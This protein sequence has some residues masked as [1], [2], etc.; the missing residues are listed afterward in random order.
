MTFTIWNDKMWTT[1]IF[2][3]LCF[4]LQNPQD[5]EFA[6]HEWW[7]SLYECSVC[8]WATSFHNL[9]RLPAMWM[10]LIEYASREPNHLISLGLDRP[11]AY[12]LVLL[13]NVFAV[14]YYIFL[15]F[16]LYCICGRNKLCYAMFIKKLLKANTF[17]RIFIAV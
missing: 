4:Y 17:V 9:I 8:L 16:A 5:A 11:L 2:F 15:C 12:F 6:C 14:M 7:K 1:I 13:H 10:W 3:L